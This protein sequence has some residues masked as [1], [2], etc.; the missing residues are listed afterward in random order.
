MKINVST[1]CFFTKKSD[2]Q[3]IF[4]IMKICLL[5]LF[6]FLFQLKAINSSAQNAVIEIKNNTVTINQLISEIEKQTDYLV[7]YSNREVDTNRRINL[8]KKSDRVAAYLYE[9]FTDTDISY[10]FEN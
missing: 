8:Q 7:V 2:P 10:D 3:I 1:N 4:K 9:A 5:F 6:V